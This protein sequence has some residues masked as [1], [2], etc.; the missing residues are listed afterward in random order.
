M[1]AEYLSVSVDVLPGTLGADAEVLGAAA[2][3]AAPPGALT[4]TLG[5]HAAAPT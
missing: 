3:A 1:A 2:L 4:K 5:P